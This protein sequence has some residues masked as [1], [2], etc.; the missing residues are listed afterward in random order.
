M[1]KQD[2]IEILI[3]HR[4]IVEDCE[5]EFYAIHGSKITQIANEIIELNERE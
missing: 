1:K 3:K 2:I 5:G 4:S